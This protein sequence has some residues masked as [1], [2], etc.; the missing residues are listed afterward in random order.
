MT[1]L[2]QIDNAAVTLCRAYQACGHRC[3]VLRDNGI[4]V[5]VISQQTAAPELAEQLHRVAHVIFD[6]PAEVSRASHV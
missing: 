2:E 4:E 3:I 1:Q 5:R 6:G